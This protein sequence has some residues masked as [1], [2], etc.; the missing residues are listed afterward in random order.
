VNL[1]DLPQIQ[2]VLPHPLESFFLKMPECPTACCG[3]EW[4]PYFIL[5]FFA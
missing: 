5:A 2:A 3:D 1:L 4:H